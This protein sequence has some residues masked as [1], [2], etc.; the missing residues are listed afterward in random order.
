MG[1]RP[2]AYNVMVVFDRQRFPYA[3]TTC[4]RHV[5]IFGFIFDKNK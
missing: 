5:E 2:M 1:H 4:Q 3:K